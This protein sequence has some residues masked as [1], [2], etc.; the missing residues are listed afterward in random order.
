MS[1][2]AVTG[3]VLA[4]AWLRDQ[5]QSRGWT[6]RETARRLVQAGRDAGDTALPGV[7]TL[8]RYVHRWERGENGLTERYRLYYCLAFGIPAAGFGCQE[9]GGDAPAQVT[10]AGADGVSVWAWYA[11]GRLVIEISGLEPAQT[12]AGPRPGLALVTSP[13]PPRSYGGRA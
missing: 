10:A 11:C 8:C 4:G 6:K 9:S 13:C 5:R 1:L 3:E 2:P 12:R 7:D